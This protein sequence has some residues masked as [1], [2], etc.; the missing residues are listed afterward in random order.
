MLV[1]RRILRIE[2]AQC[3]PAGIVFYPQYFIIFDAST[4]Q[5]FE[6]TGL[7]A[8]AIRATYH[9]VGFPLIESGAKFLLPCHFDDAVTVES[10]IGDWGRTSFTVRHRILKDGN[11]PSVEGFEKR[12]WA[13]RRDDG[14]IKP[15]PVPD[16]V[17][18]SLSDTS[19]QT[20][21]SAKA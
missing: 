5:L 11:I 21:L 17:K 16:E 8:S 20:R 2:W 7:S 15:E 14:G 4:G 6:R 9:I 12:I 13:S 18:A 3:D 10:Q 1:H 19:G